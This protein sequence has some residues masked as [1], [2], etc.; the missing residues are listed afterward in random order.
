[1]I[2][3]APSARLEAVFA[4]ANGKTQMSRCFAAAPLKIA[5]TFPLDEPGLGPYETGIG[6]CV[7]D[8]SPGLLAGDFYR[9]D[10]HLGENA[11]VWVSTQ[12][13][14]RVHPSR[15]NPCRLEQKICL[16]SGAWLEWFPYP[17]TLFRDADLRNNCEVEIAGN[18][19]LLMGEI[20]GAGR[21]GRGEAFEFHAWRS[22]VGVRR[23]GRLIFCSQTGLRPANFAFGRVG[24]WEDWTHQGQFQVFST[25]AGQALLNVLRPLLDAKKEVWSGASLLEEGGLSV[26]FLGRRACDLQ[27]LIEQIREATRRFLRESNG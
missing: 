4:S 18:A 15:E 27:A 25:H 23:A 2:E 14:T 22:R 10:W 7:M 6:V 16:E 24:A 12:G 21:I 8:C 26:S 9:F 13:F 17:T 1:M 3:T 20:L 19:T 11:H 5:K